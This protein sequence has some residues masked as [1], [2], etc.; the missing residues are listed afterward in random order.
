MLV[1]PTDPAQLRKFEALLD[2]TTGSVN[3]FCLPRR[4]KG[5]HLLM[6]ASLLKE[7]SGMPLIGIMFHS[8]GPDFAPRWADIAAIFNL[9]AAEHRIVHLLLQGVRPEAI[10]ARQKLSINTV[11]THI[12]H[13][14]DK[15]GISSRDDLWRQLAPYRIN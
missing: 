7:A 9:T 4:R 8:T 10:A 13:A 1:E 6:R 12:S 5:G 11:R 14:Y 2:V 3:T 15:I